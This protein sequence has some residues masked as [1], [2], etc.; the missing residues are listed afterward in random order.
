LKT[1]TKDLPS[2]LNI[3][4]YLQ[5]DPGSQKKIGHE[6][7]YFVLLQL[8]FSS[9]K[10][11]VIPTS[12]DAILLVLEDSIILVKSTKVQSLHFNAERHSCHF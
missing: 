12:L 8:Q 9:F 2:T 10:A 1:E 5:V 4:F 7:I 3:L 6:L 11:P